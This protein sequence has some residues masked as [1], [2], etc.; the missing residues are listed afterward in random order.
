MRASSKDRLEA[1]EEQ[2]GWCAIERLVG[3]GTRDVGRGY[4][5]SSVNESSFIQSRIGS[6]WKAC[7]QQ[8]SHLTSFNFCFKGGHS[9]VPCAYSFKKLS[10]LFF[11]IVH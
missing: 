9:T 11:G 3:R 10:A 4:V 1:F 5:R 2:C 7:F 8:T 6:H